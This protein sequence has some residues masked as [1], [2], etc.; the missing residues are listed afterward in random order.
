M[1]KN[2]FRIVLSLG[3]CLLAGVYATAGEDIAKDVQV[4]LEWGVKIPMRDGV[5][6]N[7]TV[8]RPAGA[9]PLPVIFTLT[10]YIADSYHDRA[11]YF[12]RRG[13]VFA[14]VDARGR[15]NS[16]GT[17]TPFAQEADDGHDI[18]EWFAVQP[19]SNGKVAM[20]GGSYA[21]Y[22]Q[23]ATAKEFPPHL[24][25]IVPA[26]AVGV[27][28]D[29]PFW[30]NISYPYT[31]QWQT[32]TSGSTGNQNIFEQE[33]F[34]HEKF[35]ELYSDHRPFVELPEVVGNLTT[36]FLDWTAHPMKDAYW[37]AMNPT[38]AEY[39]RISLPILTIT[40]HYDGDQPGAMEYY[41]QHMKLG[42]EEARAKHFLIIGPWDHAGTRT[43]QA[44]FAGWK[45]GKASLPAAA[46]RR[47][48]SPAASV[49]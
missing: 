14:L 48:R 44:E 1:K 49:H 32:L 45:F 24:A 19:W 9:G 6:L 22:N 27:G 46:T 13:F 23:W 38:E 36:D 43:P 29:F 5:R 15:G 12:S 11:W 30:R 28:T 33:E 3:A 20:W 26:A 10:P 8:Y 2:V 18:V 31:I 41:K 47:C 35:W 7:A 40:G 21:G 16:E 37:D 25:T 39:A 42:S 34:W 17:F 4:E